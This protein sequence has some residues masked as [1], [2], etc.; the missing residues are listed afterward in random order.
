MHS[1]TP[2]HP[3]PTVLLCLLWAS[4]PARVVLRA[5]HP[6]MVGGSVSDCLRT[7]IRL[8]GFK[9]WTIHSPT[10]NL[11][12][13]FSK[14]HFTHLKNRYILIELLIQMVKNLPAMWETPV[15]PLGWEDALEEEM[16][17][18]SSI[19]AWKIPWMEEPGSLQSMWSKRVGHNWATTLSLSKFKQ[20]RC[21][22]NLIGA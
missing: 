2:L 17:T 18:H 5:Q 22:R 20:V 7:R 19:L 9:P 1:H 3:E 4:Y 8:S 11:E 15:Q 6:T 13:G 21:L 14:P 16:A 12:Q 10:C